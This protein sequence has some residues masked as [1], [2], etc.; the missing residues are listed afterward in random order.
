MDA[1]VAALDLKEEYER[2]CSYLPEV[3]P[4]PTTGEDPVPPL[5]TA[6]AAG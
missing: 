4:V 1:I 3:P 2:T 6:A 5:E